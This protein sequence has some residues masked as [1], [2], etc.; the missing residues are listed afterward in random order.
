MSKRVPENQGEGGLIDPVCG[1]TV[2]PQSAAGFY[3]YKG[4]P[5]YFC[6]T[7]C[8]HKFREEPERFLNKAA[9]SM[10]MQQIE[11]EHAKSKEASHGAG[12]VYTCPMHP[13]VRR[14]PAAIVSEVRHGIGTTDR[15]QPANEN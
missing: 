4:K 5:Y 13:E 3:E 9:P 8:L 10:T 2:D 6:S 14:A 7:Q 1:M 12:K 15:H 11:I